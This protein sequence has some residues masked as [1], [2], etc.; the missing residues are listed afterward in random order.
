MHEAT[1]SAGGTT[2]GGSGP[3]AG[4]CDSGYV[5]G[6][7]NGRVRRCEVLLQSSVGR[8]FGIDLDRDGRDEI[9]IGNSVALAV[10]A[11]LW[12]TGRE[13]IGHSVAGGGF[14]G[15]R[16]VVDYDFDR[17]GTLDLSCILSGDPSPIVWRNL[18][19]DLGDRIPPV[20]YPPDLI[21]WSTGLPV[22]PNRDGYPERL[23]TTIQPSGLIDGLRLFREEDGVMQP[24]SPVYPLPGCAWPINIAHADFDEDGRDDAVILDDPIVCDGYPVRY[25]PT[26]HQVHPLLTRPETETME[27]VESVPIGAV[28]AYHFGQIHAED[29]TDDGHADLLLTLEP[30]G[31]VSLVAGRGDG[32]FEEAAVFT[33]EDAGLPSRT[34]MGL[35]PV[36][37]YFGE[38]DGDPWLEL[39]VSDAPDRTW[40]LD[41]PQAGLAVLEIFEVEGN[42]VGVGDFDGDGIDDLV[43]SANPESFVLLSGN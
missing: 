33:T 11:L 35:P 20:G 23:L 39:V 34:P 27:P 1:G 16:C 38:F 42:P 8:T 14:Y 5:G 40:V 6:D 28:P 41:D 37:R 22:D 29:A 15:N 25:D 32:T 7:A 4:V 30:P 18:G 36:A 17:D 13:I 10:P 9:F 21:P 19:D 2:H 3:P 31:L 26:W 24:D 43:M 12:W